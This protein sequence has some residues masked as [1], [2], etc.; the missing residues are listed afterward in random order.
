M[1]DTHGRHDAEENGTLFLS[2][3][4]PPIVAAMLHQVVGKGMETT[5]LCL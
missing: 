2:S 5:W 4:R 3:R 1:R